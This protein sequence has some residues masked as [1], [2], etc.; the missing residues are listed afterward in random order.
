MKF[1]KLKNSLDLFYDDKKFVR[2]KTRMDKHV[3]FVFGNKNPSLLRNDSYFTKLIILR[4]HEKVFHIGLE[5][6]LNNVRM[7]Y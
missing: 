2:S 4:P 7:K 5:A 1:E 6:T 3:K